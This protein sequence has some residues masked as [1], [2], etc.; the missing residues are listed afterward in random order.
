MQ[1]Y[2]AQQRAAGAPGFRRIP[3][4]NYAD[5][6]TGHGTQN[7]AMSRGTFMKGLG[8]AAGG[9]AAAGLGLSGTAKAIN[10]GP[11]PTHIDGDYLNGNNGNIHYPQVCG[12]MLS[13]LWNWTY[14]AWII[15]YSGILID[16]KT[17][18]TCAH[19]PI[20]WNAWGK[21]LSK[22]RVSF[23][24]YPD[25]QNN[26]QYG[27][28]PAVCPPC[29]P[30]VPFFGSNLYSEGNFVNFATDEFGC[31]Y[32]F[33][34]LGSHTI[35]GSSI[36]YRDAYHSDLLNVP[37]PDTDY[38][39]IKNVY[40]HPKFQ[41]PPAGYISELSNNAKYDIAIIELDRSVEGITPWPLPPENFSLDKELTNGNIKK[42]KQQF[43]IVGY[44]ANV[45]EMTKKLGMPNAEY[46]YDD[47]RKYAEDSQSFTAIDPA[48]LRLSAHAREGET[49]AGS[50]DSGGPRFYR[51]DT[52][53]PI[54]DPKSQLT[55]VGVT[56]GAGPSGQ[57]SQWVSR[58][59]T[60]EVLDWIKAVKECIKTG[61]TTCSF[62]DDT[63]G[64]I[65]DI[66]G[67][68]MYGIVETLSN[69][70]NGR[71]A[72][73]HENELVANGIATE[74]S[75]YGLQSSYQNFDM[76]YLTP[77]ETTCSFQVTD[78]NDIVQDLTAQIGHPDPIMGQDYLVNYKSDCCKNLSAEVVPW[79]NRSPHL[80]QGKILMPLGNDPPGD[81]MLSHVCEIDYGRE[82]SEL[83]A[84]GVC[85]MSGSTLSAPCSSMSYKDG[86]IEIKVAQNLAD[87]LLYGFN[88]E[89]VKAKITINTKLPDGTYK[90]PG[91]T[92]QTIVKPV[93]N[94][95]GVLHAN[96][97]SPYQNETIIVS[98]HFDGQGSQAGLV[99][100]SAN[101]NASSVA[102]MMEIARALAST[103]TTTGNGAWTPLRN[104]YFIA[105]N[106]EEGGFLGSKAYVDQLTDTE[107]NNIVAVFNME[108]MGRGGVCGWGQYNNLTFYTNFNCTEIMDIVESRAAMLPF[109]NA[110]VTICPYDPSMMNSNCTYSLNLPIQTV[111]NL[112]VPV[113]GMGSDQ[114]PF[115]AA[116]NASVLYV[117]ASGWSC[118]Y[119]KT[120]DVVSNLKPVTMELGAKIIAA[121]VL[122]LAK[123][124]SP[125]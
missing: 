90:T 97:N 101:D 41:L 81:P 95:I 55:L 65:K 71:R 72:G 59:D 44:G 88:G 113:A 46:N 114:Y 26:P 2:I 53:T 20:M 85:G 106:G 5:Q 86:L 96:P 9:I 63:D 37:N 17:V 105:F 110:Y 35:P 4:V 80:L 69:N 107:L 68:T 32:A 98:A 16:S 48:F 79:D 64:I 15:G 91:S 30:Y 82:A 57:L 22:Q 87:V 118:N 51:V 112:N 47:A 31:V 28:C 36:T 7:T 94:V 40:I 18:L 119:H 67:S 39:K 23:D 34:G 93:S 43:S 45:I 77:D 29:S 66:N 14:P 89:T 38:Y 125:L 111:Y 123:R 75:G 104:I 62:Y 92:N 52:T 25:A 49:G 103:A 122:E 60:P 61:G 12:I 42:T 33:G 115:A 108:M 84:A 6:N 3:G 117:G 13:W 124:T 21:P 19:G 83:G 11:G 24:V 10:W 1:A 70:Y 78:M 120:T 99:F 73:S 100:P 8:L 121:T 27:N 74:F 58:I 76:I 50:G 109:G 102:V 116:T 56:T 54:I